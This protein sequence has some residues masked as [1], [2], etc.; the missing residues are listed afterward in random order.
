MN[1][2][3]LNP[4]KQRIRV[5]LVDDSA[6]A[7]EFMR[8]MLLP[9]PDI[10]VV[11]TAGDGQQALN[12]IGRLHPDVI[13]TDLHMPRMD[14]LA[15]T[16]EIMARRPLPVLVLSVSVQVDQERNIFS[17]LEAGALDILA[18][19]RGGEQSNFDAI[20]LDFITKIRVLAGVKVIRRTGSP[21]PPGPGPAVAAQNWAE[22][23]LRPQIIGIGAS[24]GGPQAFDRILRQ[25]PADFSLPVV[26]IQHITPGFMGGL[27][28]WLASSCKIKILTAENGAEPMPGVAYFPPDDRH[29]EID[30]SG[31]LHCSALPASKGHR[32][33]IDMC[34][35]SIA[36]RYGSAATGVLLTGMGQ[37]GAQGLLDI[38]K[39]GG[40]TFAQN[41]AS[42]VVFG[43]PRRA[44][45]IGAALQVLAIEQIG[46]ALC[47][48][49]RMETQ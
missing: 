12:L 40:I 34:L 6:I 7:L 32:P 42:S 46:P 24:T 48:L 28:R 9:A 41:E 11:G 18:K 2:S 39:A 8:R 20:A 30:A 36:Q 27:V 29:L 23:E 4:K 5:L 38:R 37:D 16:R 21:S 43:M 19:P 47:R 31:R 13:C 35:T 10:E 49:A 3:S 17:M 1:H 14:G 44:M 26:C 33:S 25:L 15:L 22:P 45:E